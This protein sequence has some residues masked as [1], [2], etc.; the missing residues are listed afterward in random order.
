M[1]RVNRDSL[2]KKGMWAMHGYL[3]EGLRERTYRL[4]PALF[5]LGSAYIASTNLVSDGWEIVRTTARMCNE[6]V[7]LAVLDGNEVLYVA[8]EEGTNT[9]RMVSAVGKRFPAYATGVGKVLLANLSD[10][11]LL[12]RIPD[13]AILP[14]ITTSTVTNPS[15]LRAHIK[16]ARKN[17]YAL[18]YEESTPGLCCVAAPVYDA[19]GQIVA[20]MSVSVP[21]MR[22]TD[23][24]RIE[25]LALIRAQANSLSTILGYRV[26]L[27]RHR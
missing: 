3:R 10:S 25:L 21:N 1:L 2:G 23:E 11:E 18:D 13:D 24:R 16:T 17:G 12:Q 7:H 6:T 15:E 5:E 4:G 22:F 8:K 19:Q 14:V 9:I 26:A 27:K 20:G